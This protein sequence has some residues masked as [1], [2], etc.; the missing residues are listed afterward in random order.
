MRFR[1]VNST[2]KALGQAEPAAITHIPVVV[3]KVLFSEMPL[4]KI[5]PL[6]HPAV[7][8]SRPVQL[9]HHVN[10]VGG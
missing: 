9:P 3:V 1:Q 8:K 10:S 7:R 2:A 4:N 5:L 6:P